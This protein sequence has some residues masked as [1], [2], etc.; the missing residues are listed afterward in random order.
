M[1]KRAMDL[2]NL[3]KRTLLTPI[4]KQKEVDAFLEL[5]QLVRWER[6]HAVGKVAKET[7]VDMHE[8]KTRVALLLV[9]RDTK[10]SNPGRSL[11]LVIGVTVC[12]IGE[13]AIEH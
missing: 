5:H 3:T 11:I 2:L 10:G 6:D 7:N 1:A 4:V 13:E 8:Q 12:T 9:P